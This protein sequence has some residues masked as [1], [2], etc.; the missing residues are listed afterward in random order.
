[1]GLKRDRGIRI[2]DND[3][4]IDKIIDMIMRIINQVIENEYKGIKNID[5]GDRFN[6]RMELWECFKSQYR[7]QRCPKSRL[8][9]L[10][11]I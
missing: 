10:E 8:V 6:I 5:E 1:M 9:V 7:V 2:M 3:K 4:I 11:I